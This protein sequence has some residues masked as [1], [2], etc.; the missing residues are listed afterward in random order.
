MYG[1]NGDETGQGHT[2][3]AVFL[4]Y[5]IELRSGQRSLAG[6]QGGL[7][8][9]GRTMFSDRSQMSIGPSSEAGVGL[10]H[11]VG[12]YVLDFFLEH[13]HALLSLMGIE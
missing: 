3:R 8:G 12:D 1:M 6:L 9:Y 7:Q 10:D 2:L 5:A 4:W 11:T 13:W